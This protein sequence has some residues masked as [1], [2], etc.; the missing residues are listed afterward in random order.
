MLVV[1]QR[2]SIA[3]LL[4]LTRAF[5]W[6]VGFFRV[7]KSLQP[8][9]L[10]AAK[11]KIHIRS[12]NLEIQPYGVSSWENEKPDMC[13]VVSIVNLKLTRRGLWRLKGYLLTSSSQSCQGP[14]SKSGIASMET[15]EKIES[16]AARVAWDLEWCRTVMKDQNPFEVDWEA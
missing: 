12:Q 1:S 11:L 2:R 14:W 9:T 5:S 7:P 6:T 10:F 13:L 15:L 3:I 8:T 4:V 16:H